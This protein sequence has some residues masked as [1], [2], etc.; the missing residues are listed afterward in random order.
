MQKRKSD[1]RRVYLKSMGPYYLMLLPGIILII[2]FRFWPLYGLTAAFKDYNLV[3][4]LSECEW[5]GVKWFKL[6]FESRDFLKILRNTMVI[7]ILELLFVFGGSIVLAVL[8]NEIS[9]TKY[10]K[11]VQTVSYIP[12]F[13]SWV[14]VGGLMV[15]LLASTGI[16]SRIVALVTNTTPT[17]LLLKENYFWLIVSLGEMWKSVGWGTILFLAAM[18]GINQELYEAAKID[19]ASRI[20]RILHITLPGIKYIVVLQMLMR[21]GNMMNVGF[22]KVFVLQNDLILDTAEVFSTYNYKAGIVQWRT[23]YSTA[24]SV[25]ESLVNFA[26]V[27]IFD[28]IA[29]LLG[30]EGLL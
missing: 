10:K 25:F 18:S 14:V 1:A 11:F 9:N 8:I 23:S 22:E 24:L 27:F 19:G 21:I 5:V 4:N 13:L 3:K 7:N 6:L 15:Q 30:E 20:Q 26:L 29:K 16:I 2:L 12:H 28:R 17:N